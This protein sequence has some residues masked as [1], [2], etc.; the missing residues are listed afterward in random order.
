VRVN[1]S[2]ALLV[3]DVV[4]STALTAQLGDDAAA[5]LWAAHDRVARDLLPTFHG[6]E[7]DKSDG[8]L[9][10]FTHATEA[11]GYAAAYH[12][13][14]LGLDKPLKARAGLHVG[15]V[16]LRENS[17]ADVAQGAK[18]IE[19]EGIAKATA[20]RIMSVANGGQT[21]LSASAKEALL[22]VPGF[23]FHS[24]GYWRLK[25][26]DKPAE[27]FEA[28][29]QDTAFTAP[30]GHAKAYRVVRDGDLWLPLRQVSSNLPAERDAFVG[31]HDALQALV[32]EFDGGARLLSVTGFGGMGKTRL[33]IRFAWTSLG[34]FPG[35]VWFCDLSQARSIGGV[36]S[37][38]G[39]ALDVP[40]GKDDPL[41]QL[42]HAIHARGCCLVILDNFEQVAQHAEATLGQWLNRARDARFLVT[43]RSVLGIAGESTLPLAPLSTDDATALFLRRACA[44]QPGF[45]P[46]GEDSKAIAPLVGLLDGL[47]LAIELAAARVRVMPPHTLLARMSERFRLLAS[48]AGRHERQ[49]TLR[50]TFDWS[51]DLLS[52][53]E[54][55]ALAQLSVFEG[56]FT[57]AAAEAVLES[58]V[59]DPPWPPDVLQ[60]LVEKSFVRRAQQQERFDLLVSVR[61]YASQRLHAAGADDP[62]AR[63]VEE[64]HGA[65]FAGLDE[66]AA[67]AHR[68]V[69]LDNMVVACRRALAR[70]DAPNAV[71]ALEGAWAGL[72]LRGP[73]ALAVELATQV[74]ALPGLASDQAA[75]VRRVAGRALQALGRVADARQHYDVALRQSREAGDRACEGRLL[76][77]LGGMDSNESRVDEAR[78]NLLASLQIARDCGDGAL[79]CEALNGLGTL[80]DY[81]GR[82]EQARADYEAALAI[83]RRIG[84]RRWEGG[85]LGNLGNLDGNQGRMAQAR[86]HFQ[87]GLVVARELGNR[88]WEGNALCNLGLLHQVQGELDDAL[89]ALEQSLQVAREMGHARLQAI[90]LCNLGITRETLGQADQA[91]VDYEAALAVAHDLADRRLAG[92]F[93]GY[94]GALNARQGDFEAGER[95]LDEG[96]TL[97]REAS[98]RLHLGVLLCARAEMEWR[99]NR[100][101][102]AEATLA[103][104]RVIANEVG[105]GGGSEL[106]A[107]MERA[108]ALIGRVSDTAATGC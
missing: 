21:L 26:L 103:E 89:H 42:G 73:F 74:C 87:A 101:K 9:L 20:A 53:S 1:H 108:L 105:A 68:C 44:I 64:R 34:D 40:L 58:T 50:A 31:R 86:V 67:T 61:E 48:S 88:Q 15:D 32:R 46:R 94:L 106:A 8:L 43:S 90:V 52:P 97:L 41:V 100:L 83:A 7:I 56:G 71:R 18:S 16:I 10:L 3:T 14:L 92:Q 63:A 22:G 59:D 65:F 27:L 29:D 45:E 107:A 37:A 55:T 82:I 11:A 13:A 54:R 51:W 35:G 6:R 2:C 102:Q 84:D 36:A 91:R 77:S 4:D 104:V 79:E 78:G 17:S 99:V 76:A 39:Q 98:D 80:N 96:A 25:G 38:V 95:Q 28:S 66:C 72:Q 49:A 30:T 85:I 57:L 33:A 5:R 12:H 60:S 19:V 23:R 75:R 70:G 24:H 47:P 69:E 81:L 62:G 93:L